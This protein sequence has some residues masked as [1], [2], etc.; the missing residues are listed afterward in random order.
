MGS[1]FS[2]SKRSKRS[3]EAKVEGKEEVVA[4]PEAAV[5]T[6]TTTTTTNSAKPAEAVSSTTTTTTTV[7]ADHL[8][9]SEPVVEKAPVV[10]AEPVVAAKPEPVVAPVVVAPATGSSDGKKVLSIPKKQHH[11]IIGAGGATIKDIRAQTGVEIDIPKDESD[12][13]TVTGTPEG[14]DKAVGLIEKILK[15]KESEREK[16]HQALADEHEAAS[17]ATGKIFD[18]YKVRIDEAA[19]KR[20]QY[21]DEANKQYEAGNK[22]EAAKLR[23]KAKEETATM[24]RLQKEASNEVFAHLN[25]K[26]AD[27]M[28][29]D[30]H[31]QYVDPAMELLKQRIAENKAAGKTPLLV[32]YGAGN[33]SDASG[34]K[35]KPAVR[36]YLDDEG[37]TY[38][39]VNNGSVSVPL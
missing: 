23:E 20:T 1:P 5:I 7:Q 35:I 37:L 38:T 4:A 3:K 18:K 25:E 19:S 12:Q 13:V 17:Q 8:V 29:I 32:I 30:L 27:K 6:T 11:L 21:F 28:T 14:V 34:A 24:E 15:D 9:K 31:G 33:H 22:D 26:Y 39:E 2:K 36:K 16:K 10:A